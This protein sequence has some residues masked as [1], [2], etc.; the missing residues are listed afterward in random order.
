MKVGEM[1]EESIKKEYSTLNNIVLFLNFAI[2]VIVGCWHYLTRPE[3]GFW[4]WEGWSI[5]V[6]VCI[7]FLLIF[8]EANIFPENNKKGDW[9]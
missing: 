3:E 8:L 2:P 4:S 5:L 9:E 7:F 6:V 1:T